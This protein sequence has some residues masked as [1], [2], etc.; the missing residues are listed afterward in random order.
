MMAYYFAALLVL[1][2]SAS[3]YVNPEPIDLGTAGDYAILSKRGIT[4]TTA[5]THMTGKAGRMTTGVSHVTG[6]MATSS[7]AETPMTGFALAHSADNK[8]STSTLVTGKVRSASHN[9]PTP[10]ILIGA[11]RN[12]MTAYTAAVAAMPD[13]VNMLEGNLSHQHL[14]NGVY[15]WTS[16]VH[17][18]GYLTFHGTA[19]DV[20]ILQIAGDLIVAS[21][22]EVYLTGGAQAKNIFWQVTGATDFGKDSTV[23]GVFLVKTAMTFNAGSTLHGAALAQTDVT[24]HAANI[25]KESSSP[26]CRSSER[27]GTGAVVG[28]GAC[29]PA[30]SCC[31]ATAT[32]GAGGCVGTYACDGAAGTIG[33]G[34]CL[35][36]Y[37]CDGA[38][39]LVAAGA[40]K[41]PSTC[42]SLTS[43]A[44]IG[45]RSCIG[46]GP[47]CHAA[48]GLIGADS[49][50]GNGTCNKAAAAIAAGSCTRDGSC[51]DS[52]GVIAAG[53]C[54]G[55]NS[56]V[57]TGASFNA[58]AGTCTGENSCNGSNEQYAAGMCT[59]A[60]SC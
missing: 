24:L 33:A 36:T 35:G 2:A 20:F 32:I 41:G 28:A 4:T 52:K 3:A 51:T 50:L 15:K 6:N 49:C 10:N 21:G 22:A 53:S 9:A 38:A 59:A 47:N 25:N 55:V 37:A 26:T 57:G 45:A 40:C 13:S 7:T 29:L 12:M 34:G 27:F 30:T 18:S 23:H 46:D 42:I 19:S 43:T 1:I 60:N 17:F 16:T 11:V 54:T 39:G 5:V 48:A 8:F 56:C 31:V 14:H 44:N 58:A